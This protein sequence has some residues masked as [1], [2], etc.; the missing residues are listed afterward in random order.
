MFGGFFSG[1]ITRRGESRWQATP[2]FDGDLGPG[3]MMFTKTYW[4][5]RSCAID[6]FQ[7]VCIFTLKYEISDFPTKITTQMIFEGDLFH[8]IDFTRE[9]ED[10]DT[11]RSFA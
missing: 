9:L 5:L 4:A 10:H 2:K 3:A 6:P 11:L 7:V 1:C 8:L